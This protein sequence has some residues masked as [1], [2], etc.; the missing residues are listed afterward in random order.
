[1][2]G[3]SGMQ[4]SE[5]EKELQAQFGL[6]YQR[7]QL[8]VIQ[9][10]ERSVCGCA[11]GGTSWA[12]RREVDE[13]GKMLALRP[14]Q[15]LMDLGAGSG[16]PGLYLADLSGCDITLVDLPAEG[17]TIAAAR[18][19]ADRLT[20]VCTVAAADGR[21]LPFGEN[22][23]DAITHSDV[24]CCLPGKQAVLAECRR[25]IR[26]GG[27]MIFSVISIAPGLNETDHARAIEIGPP[28][29]AT[30][31]D[32]NEMLE[33]SGWA[34]VEQ[35]DLT[36]RYLECAKMFLRADRANESALA[37]LLGAVDYR[38][39]LAKDADLIDAIARGLFRRNL[40]RLRAA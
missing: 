14:N 37:D 38:Q 27:Q 12:T 35:A 6:A 3:V 24:L 40:H 2:G 5:A 1:M 17:L 31:I 36:A 39:R 33:L 34:T 15:R 23:F 22:S 8:P 32:Y 28:Y 21:A 16:W 4:R 18:A 29:V 13:V 10:I 30:E 25:T 9:R 19:A 11:Y 26:D 20:G 7:N